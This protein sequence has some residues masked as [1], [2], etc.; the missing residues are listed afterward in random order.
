MHTSYGY[1]GSC[2]PANRCVLATLN[3][4]LV[5]A[6]RFK[7]WNIP[8]RDIHDTIDLSI[9]CIYTVRVG[10]TVRVNEESLRV[11]QMRY[12]SLIGEEVF[13]TIIPDL[14]PVY[15]RGFVPS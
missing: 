7:P 8:L 13:F 2:S 4:L 1:A 11:K 12:L 15:F 14:N 9:S 5:L 6:S 10:F 3:N